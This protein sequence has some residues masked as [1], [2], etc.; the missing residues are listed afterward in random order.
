[1]NPSHRQRQAQVREQLRLK[2][3][4]RY[5]EPVPAATPQQLERGSKLYV[6]LCAP[7]HGGRGDGKGHT[8]VAL[9]IPPSVFTDREQARFFSEQAR[10]HIIRKGMPGTAMMGW[11][12]VLPEKD[13]QALYGY[14]RSL[15][16]TR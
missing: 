3:G 6:Q 12:T 1:M 15:I 7:C 11:E 14:I 16:D 4:E 5:D 8:G 10:L 13:I 2:L 9:A